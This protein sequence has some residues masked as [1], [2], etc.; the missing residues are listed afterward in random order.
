MRP[1]SARWRF[2]AGALA[3]AGLTYGGLSGALDGE[4]P[5]SGAAIDSLGEFG[6]CVAS[7]LTLQQKRTIAE[8]FARPADPVFV[9]RL[10][11]LLLTDKPTPEK[12]AAISAIRERDTLHY[13]SREI[14]QR[15]GETCGYRN[16]QHFGPYLSVLDMVANWLQYDEAFK[17]LLAEEKGRPLDAAARFDRKYRYRAPGDRAETTLVT[18]RRNW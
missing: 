8:S 18:G 2:L 1:I 17:A 12:N 3:L 10:F 16:I 5:Q 7:K 14:A 15:A 4:P 11:P 13:R 6:Y 9:G